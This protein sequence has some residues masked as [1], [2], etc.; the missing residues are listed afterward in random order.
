M[1]TFY[2]PC[3]VQNHSD[4]QRSARV[5]KL[6]VDT[7]SEYT[8]IPEALLHRIGVAREKKDVAFIMAKAEEINKYINCGCASM[9]DGAG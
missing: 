5:P 9:P 2:S 4:R 8:W 3:V 7:G 6:L 1:G